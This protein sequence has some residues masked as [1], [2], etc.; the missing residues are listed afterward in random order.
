VINLHPIPNAHPLT[1]GESPSFQPQT[2]TS[3]LRLRFASNQG[4]DYVIIEPP[5]LRQIMNAIV[6]DEVLVV[7]DCGYYAFT[8]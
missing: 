7:I 3:P 5:C 1:S 4:H 2:A 6:A 8:D